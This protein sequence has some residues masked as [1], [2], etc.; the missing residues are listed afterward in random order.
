MK[1]RRL[2]LL[3]PLVAAAILA[4]V[5]LQRAR[6]PELPGY[7]VESRPLVQVVV[8]VVLLQWW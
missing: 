5:L 3:L 2:L 6:G 8:V 4:L 1:N 7:T